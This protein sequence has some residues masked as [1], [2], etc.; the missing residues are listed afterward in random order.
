MKTVL[1]LGD[2]AA[3]AERVNATG[4]RAVLSLENPAEADAVV[5][6]AGEW[7]EPLVKLLAAA[8]KAVRFC[9]LDL[10]KGTRETVP[11]CVQASQVLR[12]N[13]E[14]AREMA[15]T[16]GIPSAGGRQFLEALQKGA[17]LDT[18]V[19]TL[20]AKAAVARQGER[21]VY[22]FGYGKGGSEAA[23]CAGFL[24]ARLEGWTLDP[25]CRWGNG[26]AALG[27]GPVP[28]D[29]SDRLHAL[30]PVDVWSEDLAY[31]IS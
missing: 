23:F 6:G 5:Y 12:I 1:C 27:E 17:K 25:C 29:W 10:K 4:G 18:V 16:Y 26:F 15:A 13:A 14:E 7:G 28:E 20:G 3:L 11:A 24:R 31:W 19:V 8:K 22:S 9:D 21:Q 30:V 2:R